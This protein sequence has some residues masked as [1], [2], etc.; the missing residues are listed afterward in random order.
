MKETACDVAIIGGGA[1]GLAAAAAAREGGAEKVL[2]LERDHLL[3]GILPQCIHTGFGLL[4]FKEDLTGPEYIHR[5]VEKSR[6]MKVEA[7]LETMVLEVGP[8]RVI[9]ATST[10]GGM[11]RV[12]AGAVVLAMGCRERTRG[13]LAI[14]G[15]RP[16]GIFT[17]GQAQRFV[18]IEGYMPGERVVILGSGD[19]GM[20]M[21]RRLTFEGAKVEA[22]VEVLPWVGGLM[23]NKVQ[24]LDDFGIPLLLSHTVTQICGNQ[25]VTAV[26]VAEVDADRQ[27]DLK[28]ERTIGCDTLLLSVG[29][30]PE[31]ELTE[32]CGI[33]MDAVTGGALLDDRLETSVPG[34]F[35]CGNVAHVCD[36]VDNVTQMGLAA[37][38]E[39]ARFAG[40]KAAP[41]RDY[42]R[43]KA[44]ENV[45]YVIPQRVS[46]RSLL[47]G[48]VQVQLRVARPGVNVRLSIKAGGEPVYRLPKKA[49]HPGEALVGELSPKFAGLFGKADELVVDVEPLKKQGA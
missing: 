5:W 26:K 23:R 30:I 39:A 32:K 46:R 14:P 21:A 25:R 38:R 13:A 37:G 19:V 9:T 17:A 29:L 33:E 7:K 36:I 22:V 35:A 27:P 28:T 1:A 11:M 42:I 47:E 40:G 24:C 41:E 48:N 12:K 16:A 34:I 43:L 10:A 44:G 20:I 31:N 3:G 6:G 8:D 15:T 49:V 2:L 4:V 45:R 18:N